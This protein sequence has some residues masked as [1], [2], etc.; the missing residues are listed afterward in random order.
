MQIKPLSVP[1][2]STVIIKYHGWTLNSHKPTKWSQVFLVKMFPQLKFHCRI[3]GQRFF[4][5]F[6]PL[7]ARSKLYQGCRAAIKWS[8]RASFTLNTTQRL[9]SFCLVMSLCLWLGKE[10]LFVVPD[11]IT[12]N[13]VF[14]IMSELQLKA[15]CLFVGLFIF[16]SVTYHIIY[17]G[18]YVIHVSSVI[19]KHL[20][21]SK[22]WSDPHLDNNIF[23][24]L[25]LISTW[26]IQVA[27]WSAGLICRSQ[28]K[29]HRL[30][31]IVSPIQKL[32]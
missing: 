3:Q 28:V 9:L 20:L 29:G 12:I 26:K 2:L 16:Y 1:W 31:V 10:S 6:N 32:S 17:F 4:F 30:Q 8:K 13:S 21:K 25:S 19:I 18:L 27:F 22:R 23:K 7:A 24:K 11:S 15:S 14:M 5:H